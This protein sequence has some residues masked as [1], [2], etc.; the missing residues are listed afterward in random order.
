M[1]HI[2]YTSGILDK[3]PPPF[4]LFGSKAEY[5]QVLWWVSHRTSDYA[6]NK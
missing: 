6:I 3:T 5:V 4:Y 1:P 2:K